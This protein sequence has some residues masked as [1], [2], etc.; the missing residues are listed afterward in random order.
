MAINPF[1]NAELYLAKNP[2][3][4]RAGLN[5]PEQLWNHYEEF[6]AQE[7]TT[8]SLRAPNAWFD[9]NYY[10]AANPDLNAAGLTAADALNHYYQYGVFESREFSPTISASQFDAE[11]Y[12]ADN[13]D[14]RTAFGIEEDAELTQEQE[15]LLLQ[16]FLSYGYAENRTGAGDIA[17]FV[18]TDNV[19]VV[20]KDGTTIFNNIGTIM[21]DK[22]IV[23]DN[24]AN[25]TA[26]AVNTIDGLGGKDTVVFNTVASTAVAA[27]N[28]NLRNIEQVEVNNSAD[29]TFSSQQLLEQIT[30]GAAAG[31][32][33]ANFA[34]NAVR[35]RA[36]ELNV[37]ANNNDGE[38]IVNGIET[39][40]LE[41]GSAVEEFELASNNTQ[42][43]TFTVNVTGASADLTIGNDGSPTVTNF[44][45][46]GSALT[47]GL[48]AITV[49]EVG[50]DELANVTN[51]TIT[52]SAT[53]GNEFDIT[54]EDATVAQNLTLIGGAG[55]D[56][57]EA[58][59][60]IDTFTGGSGNDT[61]EFSNAAN[62]LVKVS[63][64]GKLEGVDTI[65]DFRAGDTL[66]VGTVL[67][68]I[69]IDFETSS[70]PEG[71]TIEDALSNA[72]AVANSIFQ[73][74]DDAY[75]VLTA[76]AV[77]GTVDDA[78]A[79]VKLAGVNVDKLDLD[80]TEVVFA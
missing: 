56:E 73:W 20:G 53:A 54:W 28:V 40:N 8:T 48:G 15:D 42:G 62:S 79:V 3:L 47:A 58:N 7:S 26:E 57:F 61:F 13:A 65:T 36:D 17:E 76:A 31:D 35:G 52:G 55:N 77:A 64:D 59:T 23:N 16:H 4:V 2:D 78:M 11:T 43:D 67:T 68:A 69:A 22:F 5:T 66:T 63:T 49:G 71:A 32:V 45:L 37:I 75:V 74:N 72:A 1:F 21:N 14:L 29:V 30:L 19:L 24:V 50:V 44:V 33:T 46:N 12:A 80:A 27:D 18:Q 9:V 41:L 51:V 6:G 34:A 38:L 70:L 39:V 10:L 60:S 25:G